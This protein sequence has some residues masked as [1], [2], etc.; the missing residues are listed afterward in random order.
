MPENLIHAK[1]ISWQYRLRLSFF[2]IQLEFSIILPT[3]YKEKLWA[4]FRPIFSF[5]Y[6]LLKAL[7]TNILQIVPER[8][9]HHH[10]WVKQDVF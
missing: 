2:K 7:A 1:Y 4:G 6:L 9:G 5:R 3:K 8:F 10:E